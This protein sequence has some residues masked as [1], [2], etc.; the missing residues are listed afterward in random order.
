MNREKAKTILRDLDGLDARCVD[1]IMRDARFVSLDADSYIFHLGDNCDA[2]VIVLS[3]GVRVRLTAASGRE[4]ILYRIAA[5]GS[6]LLTTSCL[7][8]RE[9]YPAEAIAESPV[10]A[11]TISLQS[12]ERLLASS[13]AFRAYIFKGFAQ[14]LANV[15]NRIEAV[16]LTPV[17]S[18][19]AAALLRLH[20]SGTAAV[21]HQALAVELGTAREVVSRHLKQLEGQG[22]LELGR[23]R[24]V[25]L[26]PPALQQLVEETAV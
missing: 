19:L 6:C 15:I 9:R 13:A 12:F 1:A 8:S 22:L 4:V 20:D 26:D 24:I 17:H 7:F 3:G 23:G 14:R 11:L 16:A 18:R 21:T 5:G 10:N 2:F 25:L